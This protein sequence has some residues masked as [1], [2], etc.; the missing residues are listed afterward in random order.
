[1]MSDDGS[2]IQSIDEDEEL[3]TITE[4]TE[5]LRQHLESEF[6]DIRV[7]GE[8]ANFKLHT[9]GHLYFSLRDERN[10]L[11]AVMFR[12][13]ASDLDF[14]PSDG[15]LVIASGRISHYGGSGQTQLLTYRLA[16]A[17]RGAME[18]EFRR[19]LQRLVDEGLTAP[20]RKR[21]LEPYPGKIIVITSPTGAVIKDITDTIG[22]R[23]PVAELIHLCVPVQGDE[24]AP[25]IIK[26]LERANRIPDADAVILARG[27]GSAEDL[28]TFNREDIARA[29]VD[30][31][32][33]VITGIGHEIDT[34][35]ADY[36]AD[37]RAATP[38]AAAE[39]A[40]PQID[41]V[42]HLIKE[43]TRRIRRLL[44]E[45][46]R[47]RLRLL[48]F[49]L[50]SAAFPALIHRLERSELKLD[51]RMSRLQGWWERGR[52]GIEKRISALEVEAERSV[53]TGLHQMR[54]DAGRLSERLVSRNPAGWIPVGRER[55][56]RL[57][58]ILAVSLGHM[59][60][61]RK[62]ELDG[63]ARTLDGLYP[64]KVL[65]RGYTY[66]SS[67][68]GSKIIERAEGAVPGDD[69]LVNFFDGGA[70]CRIE[71]RRKGRQWPR[72]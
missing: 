59:L 51:D 13:V 48:E 1:M 41:E 21:T 31:V 47:E 55:V 27:G 50:R 9:S 60:A 18:L 71:R 67:P 25:A 16:P 30:S 64:M 49:L 7:L 57:S 19:L 14:A 53:V 8:I 20:E 44:T 66:C 52:E 68:D 12:R 70:L 61:V 11:R 63:I 5:A 69:L 46:Q 65:K 56:V 6:P 40:A 62:G 3:Y 43:L 38:T 4:I 36:V 28:W 35:I 32:H 45:S 24:A 10:Q 22:R 34:T 26:A 23:W 17:G 39:L 42:A 37:V 54:A 15:M 33:P 72:K 29:I 2:E 58:S